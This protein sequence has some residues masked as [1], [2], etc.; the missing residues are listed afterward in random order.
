ML[1]RLNIL[2]FVLGAGL[3]QRQAELPELTWALGLLA[4]LTAAFFL[5]Q[6]SSTTLVTTGK[7]LLWVFSLGVGFF[8]A[9]AFAHWRMADS[10]PPTWESR[11]IQI[12]GVIAN[13]PQTSDR[14]VRFRFDV[15]QVLTP[16]ATVPKHISLS[17]YK[18]RQTSTDRMALPSVHAGER[19]QLTVRLKQP[20]SNAN[21]HGF[22]YEAWALERNIRA[23]GYVRQTKDNLRLAEMV[24]RPFYWIER[25]RQ[26]IQLRFTQILSEHIYAGVLITLA[27]GD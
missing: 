3:L 10:L 16:S 2:A 18:N 5:W 6:S 14:S 20:H 15:E 24:N 9:A 25:T 11:D 7:I 17:W 27:T 22:D 21:P 1:L 12:I 8:W 19:W 4:V 23:V 26:Q 13:L